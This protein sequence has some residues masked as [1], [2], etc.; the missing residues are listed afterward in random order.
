MFCHKCGAKLEDDDIFCPLCG[1]RTEGAKASEPEPEQAPTPESEPAPTPEP[2][3]EP[4]P[5]PEPEP[6]PEP[7]P[8]PTPEPEPAP[9]PDPKQEMLNIPDDMIS[10]ITGEGA[11]SSFRRQSAEEEKKGFFGNIL[12]SVKIDSKTMLLAGAAL[13]AIIVIVLVIIIISGALSKSTY[14]A[15]PT[16]TTY[17]TEDD[18]TTFFNG[19]RKLKSL[20]GSCF[21]ETND[22]GFT[23][24]INDQ[25]LYL[26][27]GGSFNKIASGDIY[28][29]TPSANSKAVYYMKDNDLFV[30]NGSEKKITTIVGVMSDLT[31][32]PNGSAAAWTVTNYSEY[33]EEQSVTFGF[34]TPENAVGYMFDANDYDYSEYGWSDS[35]YSD[36]YGTEEKKDPEYKKYTYAYKGGEPEKLETVA[37]I[38]SVSDNCGVIYA[39]TKNDKL[40][41]CVNLAKEFEPVR[42]CTDFVASSADCSQILFY[43]SSSFKTYMYNTK[44]KDAVPVGSGE[45]YFFPGTHGYYCSDTFDSF[46]GFAYDNSG[47]STLYR[48]V[49]KG[50]EYNRIKIVGS[51]D[52]KESDVSEDGKTV[53]YLRDGKIYKKNTEKEDSEPVIVAADATS[54][55]CGG[56]IKNIYFITTDRTLSWSSGD[57]KSVVPIT[58]DDVTG[59]TMVGNDVC[60]FIYNDALYYSKNGGE[61]QKITEVKEV[62]SLT[63]DGIAKDSEGRYW[64]TADGIKYSSTT[65]G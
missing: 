32:S 44:L 17:I 57:E 62:Q 46:L 47:I 9:A 49:R 7:A 18:T 33:E 1:A 21:I 25:A 55:V 30:N 24:V 15:R 48:F 6:T 14:K 61:R 58:R 31:V 60:T 38:Y 34:D 12:S 41:V 40:A 19:A 5:T 37:D 65:L 27:H 39:K 53:I 59:Y 22:A 36:A 29:L 43:D 63:T 52:I 10:E 4:A 64:S 45:I 50:E 20:E 13:I 23:F 42:G 56:N 28:N 26:S 8:A 11:F 35:Y 54:F 2:S 16:L 3:P 51:S